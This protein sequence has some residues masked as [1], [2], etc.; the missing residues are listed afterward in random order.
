MKNSVV[1]FQVSDANA[2]LKCLV[3]ITHF[4]FIRKEKMLIFAEDDKALQFVDEYLWKA[5]QE[6]FL[7]HS[8]I[9]DASTEWIGLTKIKKNLNEARFAFNLCSTPLII[10]GPF[11]TVY[12]FEDLSSPNKKLLSSSRFDGYKQ[13]QFIIES[14]IP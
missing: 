8:I 1:F 14:R 5:S 10:E 2:K 6:T 9:S 12:D 13:A 4:H 7:P 11:H 3:Q